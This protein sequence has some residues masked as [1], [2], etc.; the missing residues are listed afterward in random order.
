MVATDSKDPLPVRRRHRADDGEPVSR[1]P[2]RIPPFSLPGSFPGGPGA[3]PLWQP[4][5]QGS[6]VFIPNTPAE[7]L[8]RSADSDQVDMFRRPTDTGSIAQPALSA[9]APEVPIP[10]MSV[11]ERPASLETFS[12]SGAGIERRDTFSGRAAGPAGW[13][14]RSGQPAGTSALTPPPGLARPDLAND[15]YRSL[16]SEPPV[17]DPGPSLFSP[18]SAPDREAGPAAPITP[19]PSPPSPYATQPPPPAPALPPVPVSSLP[20]VPSLPPPPS[21]GQ[22]MPPSEPPP[23]RGAA[24]EPPLA[25]PPIQPF[26]SVAAPPVQPAPA[27]PPVQPTLPMPPA[28]SVPTSLLPPVPAPIPPPVGL[29]PVA[30]PS[31][32]GLPSVPTRHTADD[33]ARGR[34]SLSR[35][36]RR[37]PNKQVAPAPWQ[38]EEEASRSGRAVIDPAGGEPP[39]VAP[40]K[41]RRLGSSALSGP[42]PTIGSPMLPAVPPLPD[43]PADP[44]FV[45]FA[46]PAAGS[47]PRPN[48][49]PDVLPKLYGADGRVGGR[50]LPDPDPDP[51]NRDPLLWDPENPDGLNLEGRTA[52]QRGLGPRKKEPRSGAQRQGSPDWDP[53]YRQLPGRES[54]GRERI[55]AASPVGPLPPGATLPPDREGIPPMPGVERHNRRPGPEPMVGQLPVRTAAP[56]QAGHG[57]AGRNLPAAIGVGVLLGGLT[58]ASLF[59]RPE[60]FVALASLVVVLAVWEL[61]GAMA[62]KQIIVP[63]IPLAVGSLGMLVSAYLAGEEGLLVSFT[64]TGFGVLLWRII[65]GMDGALRDVTAGLFTAAYVPLLAGFAILLL[66]DV[67]GPQRVVT[68]IVVTVA[69]DIGGYIAGV[70][71]GKHPM[72]PTISPK[73]SWEGFAGSVLFCLIAGVACVVLLLDGRWWVGLILGAAAAVCATLGDLSESLLKRDLGVKDMGSLLPGHGGIMDRLDSLLPTAP[74]A[75]LLLHLLVSST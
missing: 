51:Q 23:V 21:F 38:G 57:R 55:V 52:G 9:P 15:P 3:G 6:D 1:F 41:G 49:P 29:P 45:P 7:D 34:G 74:V 75:Y 28:P 48:Q 67:D 40:V 4:V 59:T 14:T 56:P 27:A 46:A 26:Q 19:A 66:A 11:A 68:F 50:G 22:P 8:F 43:A 36:G 42:L 53:Q 73:K 37:D 39:P 71:A 5:T 33:P 65:D 63:V 2:D 10:P 54:P 18:A 47:G 32:P 25:V 20:P 64:L 16:R 35:R 60:A 12:G 61:A 17:G 30:L 58:L 62:A 69:S 44:G 70:I 31:G 72:A 24:P 13:D